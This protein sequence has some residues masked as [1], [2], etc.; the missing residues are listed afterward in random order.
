MVADGMSPAARAGAAMVL[1][2]VAYT[3]GVWGE[4]LQ[5]LLRP[6]HVGAF[7]I[8]LSVDTWATI[9]MFRFAGRMPL[10]LH[11]LTGVLALVLMAGHA[12][13][14]TRVRWTGHPEALARF[15]RISTTVW[16]VW[17]I[18]FFTGVVLAIRH[19]R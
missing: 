7:W 13:W 12:L 19:P 17:L 3:G 14:A 1:A 11:A 16:L 9:Q 5:G 8:G 10:S 15:H 18:P 6:W 4:R 2:L